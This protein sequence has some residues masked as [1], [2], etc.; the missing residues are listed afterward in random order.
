[1]ASLKWVY[2][3]SLWALAMALLLVAC[4]EKERVRPLPPECNVATQ[5]NCACAPGAGQGQRCDEQ[6]QWVSCV[7]D[8]PD[9][10]EVTPDIVEVTPDVV[11]IEEDT[12]CPFTVCGEQCVNTA[13]DREHCGGC[14]QLC[15]GACTNGRCSTGTVLCGDTWVNIQADLAH[16][17]ACDQRCDS[18][19][20][21]GVCTGSDKVCHQEWFN[22]RTEI[23][24]CG[25]C[26]NDC[27]THAN[28]VAAGTSCVGGVCRYE[29]EAGW[30]DIDPLVPGCESS[31][32]V[33]EVGFADCDG[34][35]S[36]G[37]EAD[38]NSSAHCGGCDQ[39]CAAEHALGTCANQTCSLACE[40]GWGNCNGTWDDGCEESLRTVVHCGACGVPCAGDNA[41]GNC[42]SG[43]C[44]LMCLENWG[45]C[46]NDLA[47]GCETD[48][49]QRTNCGAC[50][51]VCGQGEACM[52]GVCAPDATM[53]AIYPGGYFKGA[54][55]GELGSDPTSEPYHYAFISRPFFMKQTEVTQGEWLA[56]MGNN[57]S[58]FSPDGVGAACGMDCPVENVRWF[59]A[60]AYA[61]AL[62]EAYGLMPCYG[63][64]VAGCTGTP[65]AGN[66]TCTGTIDF[67]MDCNGY[68][69]PT[70]FEWEYA[71]RA[72][73]P[74]AFYNGEISAT[75]CSLD[76][77]LDLI[78]WHCG[79]ANFST[80][81]V[82]TRAP[83]AWGLYDMLG[84]VAEWV[85]SVTSTGYPPTPVDYKGPTAAG[86]RITRGGHWYAHVE[87]ARLAVRKFTKAPATAD[88]LVGFRVARTMPCAGSELHGVT[89][90]KSGYGSG[91]VTCNANG[92]FNWTNCHA[93][94]Y[95]T[96]GPLQVG[97][98]FGQ[99]HVTL[100]SGQVYD[101]SEIIIDA[102]GVLEILPGNVSWTTLGASGNVELFGSIVARGADFGYAMTPAQ[103]QAVVPNKCGDHVV[104]P[105]ALR[106]S[107]AQA[108]GGACTGKGDYKGAAY[109][110]NGGGCH[111]NASQFASGQ[112]LGCSGVVIPGATQVGEDGQDGPV[113]APLGGMASG[114]Y[115][116]GH[117]QL[118]YIQSR[119]AVIGDGVVDLRGANGGQGGAGGDSSGGG[120]EEQ[121]GHGGGGGAGGNGGTLYVV[122]RGGASPSI[123][124]LTAA[125]ERG[126]G[127]LGGTATVAAKN[128]VNGAP[129]VNGGVG[130]STFAGWP[131]FPLAPLDS[132]QNW[133]VVC[134]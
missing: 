7:C 72:G 69:L 110:G 62:S 117:G 95:G 100:A 83:N 40:D 1:M 114:G 33:C 82:G 67:S 125:G 45:N 53:V 18:F 57:P 17:G 97:S 6:G 20:G 126:L 90:A 79:N 48:L 3:A 132:V 124:V 50:G 88:N 113:C 24:H 19:C 75:G 131:N 116:G 26:D 61:N 52:G 76:P 31:V 32:L 85:W 130:S 105:A 108:N 47:T 74:D 134:P 71:A 70:D 14:D 10:V 25:D 96:L 91:T 98:R 34:D 12:G 129:G 54:R 27:R 23:G 89:C 122:A 28:V 13:T 44:A 103:I 42:A 80:H 77:Q 11:E 109:F 4:D 73:S 51:T 60:L 39:V 86:N 94:P 36:N 8:A 66:F 107:F 35:E 127:G 9:V 43:S 21:G 102:D 81:T 64:A 119:G 93:W 22:T 46:D 63:L 128:G 133:N 15:S 65:G 111:G 123:Q 78:A 58:Y 49:R 29:C 104:S 99:A 5:G 59:D 120:T 101:F 118:V 106:R 2:G 115:R 55:P 30:A 84:N 16:C 38:L 37:C 87:N 68:R 121:A 112:G 92:T 41:M 56:L